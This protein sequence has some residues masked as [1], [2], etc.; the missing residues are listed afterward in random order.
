ME[1]RKKNGNR[2][3][4]HPETAL[5]CLNI[6][7]TAVTTNMLARLLTKF[8]NIFGCSLLAPCWVT[9][10]QDGRKITFIYIF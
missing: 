4:S 2:F 9:G 3:E 8:H 5:Q 6:T 1:S 7:V 10:K